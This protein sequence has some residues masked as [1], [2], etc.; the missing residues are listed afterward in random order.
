MLLN[1]IELQQ[2]LGRKAKAL[3]LFHG[4][5]RVSLS[6]KSGVSAETI[7]NFE[8]TGKI[9]L[10]NFMRIAFALNEEHKLGNLFEL[11]EISSL[12]DIDKLAKPMLKR[13]TR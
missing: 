2:E 4:F 11:P 8:Q 9:N 6:E 12:K 5:K 3:R 10:E 1:P 13:G 7:R